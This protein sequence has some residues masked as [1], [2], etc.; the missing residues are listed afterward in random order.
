MPMQSTMPNLSN[1]STDFFFESHT[2]PDAILNSVINMCTTRIP[3][4]LN[5]DSSKIQVLAPMKNGTCGID[6]INKQLQNI[7]NPPSIKKAEIE[8]DG[9]IYRVGDRVMQTTNNYDKE[10]TK[11]FERGEGVFNGDI[12]TIN[13][14]E[15]KTD[16]VVV[17]FEDGRTSRYSRMDINEL[18]LSYAITIHKS[19]GSEFDVVVIPIYAGPPMLFARNLLYTAVT[20]AK[21]MVVLVGNP[22]QIQRMVHNN[23]TVKR[24]TMLKYFLT[25]LDTSELE[26]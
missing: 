11:E 7:L 12:G 2:D 20:R 22:A 17:D 19:Q 1:Q 10:W 21:K 15:P 4:F 18:M 14:I 3:K 24:N 16:E 5:I 25:R 26:F 9:V 8:K 23:Y 13:S 6:N